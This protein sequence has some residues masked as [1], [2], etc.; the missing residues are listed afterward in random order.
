MNFW[1]Y[2]TSSTADPFNGPTADS[3]RD[4]M[5]S[6]FGSGQSWKRLT[7]DDVKET[8]RTFCDECRVAGIRMRFERGPEGIRLQLDGQGLGVL[9]MPWRRTPVGALWIA[10]QEYLQSNKR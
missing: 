10:A 3:L 6:I 8:C 7:A 9:S 2:S 1:D 5:G 4:V